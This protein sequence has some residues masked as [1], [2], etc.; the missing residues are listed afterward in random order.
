MKKVKYFA[1]CST[2]LKFVLHFVDPVGTFRTYGGWEKTVPI[3]EVIS[4]SK[5]IQNF[6][7]QE[8]SVLNLEVFCYLPSFRT[9]E[10][11]GRPS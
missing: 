6:L 1:R 5:F 11:K 10:A 8:K 2:K 9:S 4:A 3:Q 7:C